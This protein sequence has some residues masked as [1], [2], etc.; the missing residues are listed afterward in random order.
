MLLD[1]VLDG[2][3]VRTDGCYIDCTFGRGGHSEAVLQRLGAHGRLY[4]LDKDTEAIAYARAHFGDDS[5]ITCIHSSFSALPTLTHEQGLKGAVD[6]LLFD[7]GVCSPQLDR[8]ERGF[9]FM[10]DGVLDMRMDTT[11]GA[12]AAEW[13]NTAGQNEIARVLRAYGEERFARRIAAAIVKTR[14]ETPVSRTGQL[15]ELISAS[16]PAREADKHPA[17]RTFQAIRI[18]INSELDELQSVLDEVLDVLGTGGRLVVIS[19]HSLEDRIVKRFMRNQAAGDPYP[20]DLPVV[21]AQLRARLKIIGKALR[22]GKQ[23][24]TTNPRARSAVLRIGE[25]IAA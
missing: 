24:I 1:E 8:G 9:S 19:F 14:E 18:F 6:G 25:K 4:V 23:E 13:L 2:L 5:R 16:V 11:T 17:T 21:A 15:A 22:P 10:R 7:L 3:A 20:P 12:T